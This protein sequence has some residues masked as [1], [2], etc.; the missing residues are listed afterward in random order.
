MGE[1]VIERF[2]DIDAEG[3]PIETFICHPER[4]GPWPAV[5][6]YM[7]APGIREELHD[8]ARRI[9]T[10]GYYVILPNLYYRQGRGITLSPECT[11]EGSS[12]FKRMFELMG[13]L[14]NEL[15]VEDTA[16]LLKFLDGQPAAR[17][18][19][20]GALGYCM[21]G[22]FAIIAAARFPDRIAA[23]ASYHGVFLAT[24]K[25]D[26]PHLLA[27]KV[28]GEVYLAFG[29]KDHLTP[30]AQIETV[31]SAFQKADAKFE[32]E[33]YPG[34]GHGFAFPNR[35]N[36]IK[37]AAERHWERLFELLGRTLQ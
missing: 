14:S 6:F 22:P 34:V 29:E 33:I 18:A 32:I 15:I 36:Y 10:V 16:A 19:R 5:I 8:M 28:R 17:K 31:R 25:P 30:P 4:K 9:A 24:D 35:A 20:I 21:S 2:V 26:S 12:E 23:A 1:V 3:G 27:D 13:T 37:P 11:V 7:D